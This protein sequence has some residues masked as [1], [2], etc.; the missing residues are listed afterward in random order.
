MTPHG[1]HRVY[2]TAAIVFGVMLVA[3]VVWMVVMGFK[4]GTCRVK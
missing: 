2:L 4:E 1:T 3:L